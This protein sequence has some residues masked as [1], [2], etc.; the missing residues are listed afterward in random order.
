MT[1]HVSSSEIREVIAHRGAA[2]DRRRI[3]DHIAA[4]ETCRRTAQQETSG[5][6]VVVTRDDGEHLSDEQ[7]DAYV[8]GTSS[9][10]DVEIV[11][12]HLEDCA[13]CAET[14]ADARRDVATDRRRSR[15]P[16]AIAAAAAIAVIGGA[17]LVAV[18]EPRVESAPA[19]PVRAQRAAA[20]DTPQWN[21]DVGAAIRSGTLPLRSDL[22]DLAPVPRSVRGPAGE[23]AHATL[24]PAGV[25]VRSTRPLVQW[26]S[27]AHATYVVVL[28]RWGSK[29][30]I[31][32]PRLSA[33]QW[34][35]DRDLVRGAT[36]EMQVGITRD[37]KRWI[38][39]A[40]PEPRALFRILEADRQTELARA[41]QKY[42]QDHLLIAVLD[43]RAGLFDDAAEQ[44]DRL[45]Q[46]G[47]AA[48][49]ARLR[50][51]LQKKR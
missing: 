50:T 43:A 39:P 44:L 18:R 49:A 45:A 51:G 47:N 25:V 24:E 40:P 3:L 46:S 32:S 31:E 28:Q 6:A 14:V 17:V 15:V 30:L 21:E 5:R 26:T 35:V 27:F 4:C 7:L 8:A 1:G 42:P 33:A 2:S 36:Y 12:T 37:G 41:E 19:R 23:A 16:L 38:V 10:A 34:H 22:A 20:Y 29:D 13:M 9:P 11:V 48:L